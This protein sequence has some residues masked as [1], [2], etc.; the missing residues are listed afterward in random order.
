MFLNKKTLLNIWLPPGLNLTIFQGTG[1]WHLFIHL[2][3]FFSWKT[4]SKIKTTTREEVTFVCFFFKFLFFKKYHFKIWTALP[5]RVSDSLQL[6]VFFILGL[7][8]TKNCGVE[9]KNCNTQ[10]IN[11]NDSILQLKDWP[12]HSKKKNGNYTW[13]LTWS[14]KYF[15][16]SRYFLLAIHMRTQDWIYWMKIYDYLQ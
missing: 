14:L 5:R 6:N 7:W 8:R 16:L 15:L 13:S 9:N 12:P 3:A 1:P 4:Q 10:L 2:N 11:S